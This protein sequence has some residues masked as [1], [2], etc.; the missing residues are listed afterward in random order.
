MPVNIYRST[1]R[2]IP[3]DGSLLPYKHVT[4]QLVT[5]IKY[6]VL[7]AAK[8]LVVSPRPLCCSSVGVKPGFLLPEN[9]ILQVFENKVLKETLRPYNILR[10]WKVAEFLNLKGK[11]YSLKSTQTSLP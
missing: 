7:Q 6:T 11:R 10:E 5:T 1:Q 9:I 8:I 3:Q 2:H 4:Q